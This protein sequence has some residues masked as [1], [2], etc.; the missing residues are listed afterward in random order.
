MSPGIGHSDG[1]Q[2]HRE[3]MEQQAV[4]RSCTKI[5]ARRE[6]TDAERRVTF[7][8]D[9]ERLQSVVVKGRSKKKLSVG[10][11]T[12]AA[13][14]NGRRGRCHCQQ[15]RGPRGGGTPTTLRRPRRAMDVGSREEG[16][17]LPKTRVSRRQSQQ[18]RCTSALS[19][20]HPKR[21]ACPEPERRTAGAQ[22]GRA[23]ARLS[24]VVAHVLGTVV[25]TEVQ[26]AKQ[27]KGRLLTSARQTVP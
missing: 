4:G 3:Q 22:L 21:T 17:S 26:G 2:G 18:P 27:L 6:N 9:T 25:Q 16:A 5:R 11:Q 24:V 1:K 14:G 10:V 20:R 19:R 13:S 7:Q 15:F 12:G 8:K 23:E